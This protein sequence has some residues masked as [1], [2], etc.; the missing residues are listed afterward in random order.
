MFRQVILTG[1]P[2]D[3]GI[4]HGESLRSEIHYTWEFYRSIFNLPESGVLELAGHF[5]NLIRKFN[6]D[7]L[8]E[9]RGIATGSGLNVLKIIALNSRTEILSHG[10]AAPTNE[11]TALCLPE[12]RLMGQTWDWAEALEPVGTVLTIAGEDGHRITMFTEPGLVGKIGMNNSG[13]GVCLNILTLGRPQK[14]LP[15]HVLLRAILDCRTA[16][17]ARML[18]LAQGRGKASNIIVADQTGDGFDLEFAGEEH[19]LI[20]GNPGYLLHT[21]HYLGAAVE[22]PQDSDFT[23]SH[24]R[25]DT[26]RALLQTQGC[27]SRA[28]L[29]QLL[30]DRSHPALPVYRDYRPDP[31]VRSCGT[32]ST[33]VM[34]LENHELFI[35]QGNAPDAKFQSFNTA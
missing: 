26:V 35:R 30:S 33:I 11:C 13:V 34:D 12:R 27:R 16:A 31:M 7:C 6:A 5:G 20:E 4:A 18:A 2:M 23:S 9:I 19:C 28:G 10:H 17:E 22:A 3:R 29:C 25:F 32:V 24:A 1:N 15:V 21:N 8:D 14:G